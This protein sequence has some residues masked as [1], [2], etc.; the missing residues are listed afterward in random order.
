MNN[1]IAISFEDDANA[2]AALTELR[3]LDSQGQLEI[4][5]ASVVTRE[6]D[7][8]VVEKDQLGTFEGLG[9]AGG[10][11]I[12]LLVGI[13]GG[14]FGILVGGVSGVLI[15]S[16]F[17]VSEMEETE[18]V[19]GE[20]SRSVTAGHPALIARVSEPSPEPADAAMAELGGTVLRR[21]V[22]DVE[23]EIAAAEKVQ[24]E[25][26]REARKQLIQERHDRDK[27]QVH[28][29]VEELKSKLHRRAPSAA[30]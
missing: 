28:A 29:K 21:S 12:G 30:S 10:G 20:I 17:D 2:Y 24:R 16:L 26:K 14:P 11:L 1:V 19:L 22:S 23:A 9:A 5:E 13:I 8:Q 3:E 25:A 7:G 4:A 6:A 27:A 15:G 18:S